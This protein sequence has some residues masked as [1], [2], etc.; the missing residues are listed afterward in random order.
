MIRRPPRSTLFP[1][2]TL[3]RAKRLTETLAEET[4]HRKVAE[5]QAGEI[6]QRRS[7]LEAEL[8]KNKQ[9]E[10]LLRQ[11]VEALQKPLRAKPESIPSSPTRMKARTQEFQAT[12]AQ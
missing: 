10:A 1:Y 11:R 8:A 2:T 6:S 7:E 12:Q 3:F 9:A 4:T 5:Q